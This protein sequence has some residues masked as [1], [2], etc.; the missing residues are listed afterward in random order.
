MG[1]LVHRAW[2]GGRVTGIA[3]CRLRLQSA[4]NSRVIWYLLLLMAKVMP[5]F[6]RNEQMQR[7]A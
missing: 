7:G 5:A 4:Q 2:I 3:G 1:D 6:C